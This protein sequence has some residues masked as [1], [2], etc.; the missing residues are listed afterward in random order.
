M[1]LTPEVLAASVTVA[2]RLNPA[3]LLNQSHH[4]AL[5]YILLSTLKPVSDGT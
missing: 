4:H 3:E 5:H 1:L 2:S